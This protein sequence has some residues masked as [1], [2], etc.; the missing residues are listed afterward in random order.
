[1]DAKTINEKMEEIEKLQD[2]FER[3]FYNK[4]LFIR[5][6]NYQKARRLYLEADKKIR[7]LFFYPS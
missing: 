6:I 1:M 3:I 7:E 5:L 4:N 2:E